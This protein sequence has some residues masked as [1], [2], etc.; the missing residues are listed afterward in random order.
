VAIGYTFFAWSLAST[1][2][3]LARTAISW[4]HSLPSAAGRQIT[5]LAGTQL[6]SDQGNGRFLLSPSGKRVET[7]FSDPRYT[8]CT[9]GVRF[10]DENGQFTDSTTLGGLGWIND[11]QVLTQDWLGCM[12][13]DAGETRIY[14][15]IGN[16]VATTPQLP[17]IAA[18]KRVSDTRVYAPAQNTIYDL[19]TGSVAWSSPLPLDKLSGDPGAIAGPKVVFSSDARLHAETY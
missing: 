3:L 19:T 6:L 13:A 15:S 9:T 7:P 12:S 10:F 2:G 18:I 14:D 4:T 11:N 8:F 16:L 1:K 17:R 5:D